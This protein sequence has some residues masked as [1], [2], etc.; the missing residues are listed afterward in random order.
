MA[1]GRVGVEERLRFFIANGVKKELPA[2]QFVDAEVVTAGC[3]MI[4]S[5]AELALMQRAN[6]ITIDAY[7]A[8]F[9]TFRE[10]MTQ[11]ELR[12]HI[13]AAFRAA[14]GPGGGASVELRQV[15]GVPA[16]QHRAA[17]AAGRRR[18]PG[19]RRLRHRWLS[20]GHHADDGVRQTD[21]AS[22]RRLE[23]REEGAGGRRLPL[24]GPASPAKR[25]TPP[26]AR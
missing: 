1:T 21:A 7:R 8:A 24:P 9:T 18:H 2:A 23:S 5:P 16:R 10:G 3:R 17:E 15:H 14:G 25:S 20:V 11:D 26:R 4:K 6:D 22:D 19:G 13:A 12:G